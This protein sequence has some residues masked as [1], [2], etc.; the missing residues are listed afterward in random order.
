MNIHGESGGKSSRGGK[1]MDVDEAL[2]IATEL[3]R[4][5]GRFW[6]IRGCSN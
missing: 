4:G 1:Y 6:L 2:K 5:L 3:V